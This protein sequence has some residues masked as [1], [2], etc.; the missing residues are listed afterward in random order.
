MVHFVYLLKPLRNFIPPVRTIW[1]KQ[2]ERKQAIEDL[3]KT[4]LAHSDF[5]QNEE[6][7][8][9]PKKQSELWDEGFDSEEQKYIGSKWGKYL[10]APEIFFKILEKGKDKL[11]PLNEV[12]EVQRGFT[13]G[14]NEFFYLTE[15]EIKHRKIEKE[16]WMHQDEKGNWVPNYVIKSPRECK[17]IIVNPKDLKKE[18]EK[19]STI[20]RHVQAGKGGMNYQKLRTLSFQRG[21]LIYLLHIC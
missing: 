17:S 20:D 10:R 13:T 19:G 14:A 8:I 21:L 2:I 9:F 6:L 4:I 15:E 11:V 7:R 5:Y 12:A 3:I 1:E 16:F 18:N